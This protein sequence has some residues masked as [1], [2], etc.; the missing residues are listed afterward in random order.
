MFELTPLL[1][2]TVPLPRTVFIAVNY[3]VVAL[4]VVL[5]AY[6]TYQIVRAYGP[7]LLSLFTGE[8]A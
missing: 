3:L 7:V 5:N 6:I 8:D 4:F 1:V 2:P